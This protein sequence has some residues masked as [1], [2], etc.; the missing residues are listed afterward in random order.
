M[1]EKYI[2]SVNSVIAKDGLYY[3]CNDAERAIGLEKLLKNYDIVAIDDSDMVDFLEESGV[4]VFSLEKKQAK[5]NTIYRNSAKLLESPEVINYLALNNSGHKYFQTFK[6]SSR[7]E[8]LAQKFNAKILNTSSALNKKFENK[9][10]QYESLSNSDIN[11]PDTV[12]TRL[13]ETSYD[14]LVSKLGSKFVIQFDRGHTGSGTFF[15]ENQDQFAL[16][17]DTSGTRLVRISKFI[18]GVAYTINCVVGSKGVYAANLS[19]QLTGIRFLTDK[20]GGTVGNDFMH[21]LDEKLT[22]EIY[23]QVENIGKAMQK[24]G[25]V[26]LFGVDLIIQDSDV[27]VI[28][29]NARQPASIPYATKLDIKRN[30]IPLSLIHLLETLKIEHDIDPIAYSK[31][32]M[33][34]I[35]ASQIF[36]RNTSEN[37]V[38]IKGEVST[39]VYRLQSD[40]MAYH[41]QDDDMILKQ[42]TIFLDEEKDKPLVW[43]NEGYSIDDIKDGGMLILSAKSG[44][45]ISAGS[46]MARIQVLQ[47]VSNQD[48]VKQWVIEAMRAINHYL[49]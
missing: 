34:N 27:Y 36:L 35:Q 49:I 8:K 48:G 7:F 26:G 18:E 15:C 1:I 42:N 11:F 20:Q 17:V 9:I 45:E 4:S 2:D 13:N 12:I 31:E 47:S 10:S 6:I 39:G 43:Q 38:T 16:L 24:D 40:D 21:N 30:V 23:K 14:G 25:Y 44:K 28:E 29:I 37:V 32:G 41:F 22:Q 5:L 46:E 33:R 3:F 19:K